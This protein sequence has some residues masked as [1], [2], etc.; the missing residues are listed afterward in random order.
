MYNSYKTVLWFIDTNHVHLVKNSSSILFKRKCVCHLSSSHKLHA[1]AIHYCMFV[2]ME[3]N[4][5][6]S[7]GIWM[8]TSLG[9]HWNSNSSTLSKYIQIYVNIF[10]MDAHIFKFNSKYYNEILELEIF[11][12]TTRRYAEEMERIYYGKS[13][14][15]R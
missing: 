6:E 14:I 4:W 1:L 13:V 7:N 2:H 5:I 15:Y 9:S 10:T 12:D 8:F 3:M 11:T